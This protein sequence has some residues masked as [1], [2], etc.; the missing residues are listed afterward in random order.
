MI[1]AKLE[2]STKHFAFEKK[3]I[4]SYCGK[5]I[6]PD[7]EFDHHE[8]YTYYHCDCEDAIKEIEINNAILKKQQEIRELNSSMPKAKYKII[9]I[10]KQVISK[11]N[12]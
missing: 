4:C 11:I 8:T 5:E 3:A 2:Y 10:K 6:Q 7:S 9:S 12:E 1:R